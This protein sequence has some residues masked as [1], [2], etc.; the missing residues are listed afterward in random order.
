MRGLHHRIIPA[1]LIWAAAT[2]GISQGQ[3]PE[4]GRGYPAADWPFAGGD[5][6][7]SRHSTLADITTETVGRLGGAW[8]ARL[9]GGAASG[10]RRWST[11]GS[12]T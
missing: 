3:S 5:W 2:M 9:P 1:I 7:S 12:S 6:T 10:R 11:T 8:V 4:P